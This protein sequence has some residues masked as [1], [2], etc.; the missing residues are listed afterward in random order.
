M[1]LVNK[2]KL[3]PKK[4]L[5]DAQKK[6]YFLPKN[7]IFDVILGTNL[8]LSKIRKLNKIIFY[9]FEIFC[10]PVGKLNFK[11]KVLKQVLFYFFLLPEDFN[12]YYKN[13]LFT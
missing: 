4:I 10:M 6:N 7:N 1:L 2:T 5:F 11:A 12:L 9:E 8:N 3:P 13:L